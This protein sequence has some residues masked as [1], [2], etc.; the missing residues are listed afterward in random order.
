MEEKPVGIAKKEVYWVLSEV[1]RWCWY[2]GL[3]KMMESVEKEKE[4]QGRLLEMDGV[5][6]WCWGW[7]W[8]KTCW[9]S[10]F[11]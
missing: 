11:E 6:M 9:E 4:R 1:Y 7:G 3:E 2:L 10:V 8:E 5:E